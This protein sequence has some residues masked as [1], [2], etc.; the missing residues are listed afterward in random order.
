MRR[1]GPVRC[2]QRSPRKTKAGLG[3]GEPAS[4]F[5]QVL[6]AHQSTPEPRN[7]RFR[8]RADAELVKYVSEVH[9]YRAHADLEV[10]SNTRVAHPLGSQPQDATLSVCQERVLAPGPPGR[11]LRCCSCLAR[12]TVSLWRRSSAWGAGGHRARPVSLS[13][14]HR[15]AV[16][17]GPVWSGRPDLNRRPPEPHS[18]AL[19]GCATPRRSSCYQRRGRRG[20]VV[21]CLGLGPNGAANPSKRACLWCDIGRNK[22]LVLYPLV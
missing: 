12:L 10:L 22:G 19:P 15:T 17:K 7:H 21:A 2:R 16:R 13:L 5:T 18:G 20:K 8:A 6:Q 14:P 4:A 1:T 9:L 11:G 3:Q